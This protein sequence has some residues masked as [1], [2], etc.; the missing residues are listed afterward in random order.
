LNPVIVNVFRNQWLES[1]HRGAAVAVGPDGDVVFQLGDVEALVFPRS[2]LKPFQAIPLVESGAAAHFAMSDQELALACAS[3]NAEPVHQRVLSQWMQRVN[4]EPEHL[5]CGPSLPL[6]SETA[7]QHLR[8]GGEAA[9]QL[10]NCS[11]KHTGMLTLARYLDQPIEG[12]DAVDHA[13]QQR[14]ISVLSEF[15]DTD[16]AQQPWDRDGCGLPA[17]ALPLRALAL[18]YSRLC[19]PR[20]SQSR[21][22]NQSRQA[23][24][25]AITSAMRRHPDMVAGRNR[26]C[27]A[28]MRAAPDVVVK[29]GAE[30][31]FGGVCLDS[32][33]GFALKVDDG[34]SRAADAALGALLKSL[35]I[36]D[37]QC[38]RATKAFYQPELRNSQGFVVGK[39]DAAEIWSDA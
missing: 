22:Q 38:Y 2:S 1:R 10:H 9:R 36:I 8:D 39:I 27:T 20:R 26:C 13:T 16:I 32:G 5:A 35:N 24:I 19:L 14:W 31:V 3:H 6:D 7:H 28:T 37:T 17:F 15:S 11:G 29:T 21:A 12:Y 18:A 25:S 33:I 34:A 4:L 23:A 30:G